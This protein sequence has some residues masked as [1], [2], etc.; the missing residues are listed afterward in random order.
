MFLN[1]MR[2]MQL[3]IND[4]DYKEIL[5]IK[6]DKTVMTY[7]DFMKISLKQMDDILILLL[8]QMRFRLKFC[9]FCIFLLLLRLSILKNMNKLGELNNFLILLL[10]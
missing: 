9:I 3:K 5:G 7:E 10:Y 1:K 6:H 2:I 4:Y 8:M